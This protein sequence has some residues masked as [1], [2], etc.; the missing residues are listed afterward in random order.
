MAVF[1]ATLVVCALAAVNLWPFSNWELFSRLRSDQQTGWEVVAVDGTGHKRDFPILLLPHGHRDFR[2][3]MAGF[4]KRAGAERDAICVAW[5]AGATEQFGPS[6]R[7]LSIYHLEWLLSDR[8]G[9]RA[10]PA[11]LALAWTCTSKGA[12]AAG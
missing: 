1:L 10:A 8:R 12:R 6:T 5:L 2:S 3:F 7:R 4:T 9:N 11:G